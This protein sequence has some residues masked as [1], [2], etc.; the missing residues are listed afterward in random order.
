MPFVRDLLGYRSVAVVG[1]EKN[2]GKTECL[3]YILRRLPPDAPKTCVT[4]IGVDGESTDRVT[5]TRKPEITL[6]NGLYFATSESHY[7]TRNL[8]SEIVGISDEGSS[9]GRLITAKTVVEGNVILSGPSSTASLKR[10][11]DE[12]VRDYGIGLTIVDGALSRLSSASPAVSEAMVLA[13]GAALSS[14]L[15]TLVSLTAFRVDMIRLPLFKE[16]VSEEETAT[17]SSLSPVAEIDKRCKAV[18]VSGALTD[19]LLDTLM[20]SGDVSR[21]TLVVKDYTRIFIS[22]LNYNL[23]VKAGG[24]LAQTECSRLLAVCVNPYSPRGYRLDS[25]KLCKELSDRIGLP[26]YDIVKNDYE[27]T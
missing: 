11:M 17:V 13:T 15:A 10:W 21:Y 7:R 9:L 3:N 27:Q 20:K 16:S 26:V 23:F 8:V 6:R 24:C 4:S 22:P 19:R 25:D 5:M 2:C 12:S 14:N 1:M 18:F